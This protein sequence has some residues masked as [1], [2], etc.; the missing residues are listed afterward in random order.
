MQNISSPKVPLKALSSRLASILD[1]TPL[2]EARM[3]Y[4]P[5]PAKALKFSPVLKQ[6]TQISACS[7]KN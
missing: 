4:R 3:I 1:H 2:S 7:I 5:T 6:L